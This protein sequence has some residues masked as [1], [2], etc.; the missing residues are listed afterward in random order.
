[1]TRSSLP[2]TTWDRASHA[3]PADTD[4]VS[5]NAVTRALN[6]WSR[7]RNFEPSAESA[8]AVQEPIP[9][10]GGQRDDWRASC[11]IRAIVPMKS[12]FTLMLLISVATRIAVADEPQV[13]PPASPERATSPT[14]A[15]EVPPPDRQRFEAQPVRDGAIIGL[16][17]GFAGLLELINSTGEVHP[18]QVSADFDVGKLLFFDR[19]AVTQ[20]IDPN[21]S[22]YSNIGLY[23]AFAFAIADPILSGY[24]EDSV[25]AAFVDGVIYAEALSITWGVT[26]LAKVSVRRPRPIEYI[27]VKAHAGDPNFMVTDTDSSASFFSGHASTCGAITATATYLAFARSPHTARPWITLLVGTALTTFVSY[28][29]VRSGA[30]FPSDVIAGALAGG[31]IGVLVTHF[32]RAETERQ[33]PLWIGYTPESE[34]SGGLLTLGGQL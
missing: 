28:E 13:Q 15:P 33:R 10:E 29:R 19:G 21:A 24:R 6:D 1:M 2:S 32:H 17:V 26:N 14:P 18:Q 27:Q 11:H 12:P 23:A 22:T 34:G 8:T 31:G 4:D 9:N 16:S 20:T 5:A 25:Q 30:H 7:W 3:V